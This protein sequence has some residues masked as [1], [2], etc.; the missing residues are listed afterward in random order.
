MS[1]CG[2]TAS[3]V[4]EVLTYLHP[5]FACLV[6]AI[7]IGAAAER[8]RI[9]PIPIFLFLWTT[10]VSPVASRAPNP[11]QFSA[12]RF[13]YC[14]IA[15]WIWSP[16]GWAYKWYVYDYAGGGPVE[17]ASGITGLVYSLYLGP[18][19]GYGTEKLNAMRPHNVSHVFIGTVLLW[20]GWLGF[21]GGSTFAANLKA[22][23]A[24]SCTNRTRIVTDPSRAR[25]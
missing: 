19:H 18:R 7:A 23:L 15:H 25:H 3:R 20:A 8:G 13:V 1:R 24:I 6:P 2:S 14:P 4:G 12:R 5:R 16:N 17:I 9:A 10:C 11:A 22:A 21:N